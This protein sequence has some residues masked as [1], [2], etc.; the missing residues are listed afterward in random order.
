MNFNTGAVCENGERLSKQMQAQH[1]GA[2]SAESKT[3]NLGK[4]FSNMGG[5]VKVRDKRIRPMAMDRC[6]GIFVFMAEKQSLTF[7]QATKK[8]GGKYGG[9]E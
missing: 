6:H 4:C 8:A 5:T 2:K 1:Y 9:T 3:R 7:A